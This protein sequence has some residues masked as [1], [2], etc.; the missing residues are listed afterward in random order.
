LACSLSRQAETWGLVVNEAL[1]HGLPVV[2]SDRVGCAPDLVDASTGGVC[3]ADSCASL[4]AAI[5]RAT[6]LVGRLDI[7]EACRAKVSGYSVARAA[8]GI[9]EAYRDATAGRPTA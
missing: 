7:R 2:V 1:H 9:A 4:S 6:A 3:A 5:E 8:A